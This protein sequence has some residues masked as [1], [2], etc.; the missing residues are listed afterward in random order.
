MGLTGV[1]VL[2]LVLNLAWLLPRPGPP[3]RRP[4]AV[5]GQARVTTTDPAVLLDLLDVAL[6]SG[7]SVPGALVALGAAVAPDPQ[8]ADLRSVGTSLR[9]G[10]TWQE[11]WHG[12]PSQLRPLAAALEPAWCDGVDPCPLVRQEAATIRARR[13]HESREAAARLGARLVLP[14]GLCFLPAFVLLA[15]A[16][17]LLSGVGALLGP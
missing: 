5:P 2:V 12:C 3:R 8:G 4:R 9:L 14:L 1:L 15:M 7:S 17:V 11:A 10:G 6:V 13:R 16:P